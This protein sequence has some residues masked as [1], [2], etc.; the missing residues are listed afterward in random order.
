MFGALQVVQPTESALQTKQEAEDVAQDAE[1][2]LKETQA[3]EAQGKQQEQQQ[4]Q[5]QEE[6]Q[7]AN[8]EQNAQDKLQKAAAEKG[9]N[10]QVSHLAGAQDLSTCANA[11]PAYPRARKCVLRRVCVPGKL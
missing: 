6:T 3:K 2:L 5:K 4:G 8:T 1:Q 9:Q 7:A 11:D 10:P